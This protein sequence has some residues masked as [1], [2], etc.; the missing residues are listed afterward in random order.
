MSEARLNIMLCLEPVGEYFLVPVWKHS[1][2]CAI[3]LNVVMK[4]G[5]YSVKANKVI[6]GLTNS[7]V[8]LFDQFC[9]IFVFANK[10]L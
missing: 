10:H 9:K 1:N 4:Q 8:Y 5:R 6:P 7:F 3:S 2:E